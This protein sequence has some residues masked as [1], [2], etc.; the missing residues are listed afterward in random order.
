LMIIILSTAIT[1]AFMELTNIQ[2]MEGVLTR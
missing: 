2:L 1:F